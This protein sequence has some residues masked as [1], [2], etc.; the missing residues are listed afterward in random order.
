M[1][2]PFAEDLSEV[3][4]AITKRLQ[5]AGWISSSFS[6]AE[7]ARALVRDITR[8]T[9]FD[10]TG[11]DLFL[12]GIS[13]YGFGL[14]LLP[15][16]WGI[17]RFDVSAN[18]SLGRV[19]PGL[20]EVARGMGKFASWNDTVAQAAEQTAGAGWGYFFALMKFMTSPTLSQDYREW[21]KL[22]PRAVKAASKGVRFWWSGRERTTSG[23]TFA[24]FDG[25]DPDD[26]A[27]MVFQVLGATPTRI[28]MKWEAL[29]VARD[30]AAFLQGWK[31]SLY[32][33]YDYARRDGDR[34]ATQAVLE[35]MREFNR[36][37]PQSLRG[38]G[39]T[40]QQLRSS[41]RGRERGRRLEEL[42]LP[43]A[44]SQRG[45]FRDVQ[46]LFP[47]VEWGQKVK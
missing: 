27:T 44:R 31:T 33:Y 5:A 36:R 10:Q 39:F 46:D 13:R 29:G 28:S 30:Q 24:E 35:R 20:Q 16:G 14:G 8:G 45:V 38:M 6:P 40:S 7:A 25:K 15:D 23:A 34:E 11:P 9:M 4:E 37:L 1:G 3:I 2:L 26:V 47:G 12:H 21:E 18:L 17:P 19:I 42:G 43:S 32:A 41:S 22:M